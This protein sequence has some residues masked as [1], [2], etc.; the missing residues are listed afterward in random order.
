METIK[1]TTRF[2]ACIC[3]FYHVGTGQGNDA[4]IRRAILQVMDRQVAAWNTGSL[5][6]FMQGYFKSDTLRFASGGSVTYGWNTMLERYRKSYSDKEKMG[7][8]QFSEI[9]ITVITDTSALVFGTWKLKRLRDEPWGL[10]TLLFRKVSGEW[11]IVHDHTS[12]AQ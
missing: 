12:S 6:G 3:L 8:L 9:S 1:S 11:K 5:E 10:F 2:L 7:A 4:E